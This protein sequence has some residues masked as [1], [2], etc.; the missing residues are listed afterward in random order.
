MINLHVPETFAVILGLSI[1]ISLFFGS[2]VAS[3]DDGS[4]KPLEFLAI[5]ENSGFIPSIEYPPI[6]T[7]QSELSEGLGWEG[8]HAWSLSKALHVVVSVTESGSDQAAPI[9]GHRIRIRSQS[10][11]PCI[12]EQGNERFEDCSLSSSD[13]M[14]FVTNMMGRVSF[15]VPLDGIDSFDDAFPPLWIQ[16]SA[17]PETEW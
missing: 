15:S 5:A 8:Q 10:S 4:W 11:L 12:I 7:V 14:D 9:P 13:S 2:A 17:M 6:I 1:I 3:P 16:S